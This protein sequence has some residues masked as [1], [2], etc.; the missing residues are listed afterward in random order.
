MGVAMFQVEPAVLGP[1]FGFP[2]G[3][4]IIAIKESR[5]AADGSAIEFAFYVE[6][7]EFDGLGDKMNPA[8]ICPIME[9]R[10]VHLFKDWGIADR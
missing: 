7:D 3:A 1:L 4:T 5:V 8:T 2:D 10:Q 9:T 6:S